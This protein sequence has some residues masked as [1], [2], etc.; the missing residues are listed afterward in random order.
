MKPRDVVA[1]N[2]AELLRPRLPEGGGRILEIG[3]GDGAVAAELERRGYRVLA[4][5][6]SEE[7][8]ADA[9]RRGVDAHVLEWPDEAPDEDRFDAVVF[10]RSLHHME[11]LRASIARA[12]EALRPGGVLV[13]LEFDR[14]PLDPVT[15]AWIQGV[16]EILDALLPLEVVEDNFA[17]RVLAGEEPASA[18]EKLHYHHEGGEL[19]T[20]VQMRRALELEMTLELEE[21]CATLYRYPAAV[22]PDTDPA[23]DVLSRVH[24]AE[25]RLLETG[26]LELPG[27]VLVARRG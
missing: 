26:R 11:Q 6:P 12:R 5:D 24:E 25:R 10:V 1:R 18:W 7:E 17:G 9:R 3:C 20:L 2:Q 27:R 15:A 4:L 14:T 19:A 23:G 16:L 13:A 22:L 8:V 21:P